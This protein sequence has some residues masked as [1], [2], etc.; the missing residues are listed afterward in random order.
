MRNMHKFKHMKALR[1]EQKEFNNKKLLT[2]IFFTNFSQIL[3]KI[4]LSFVVKI[5]PQISVIE[6]S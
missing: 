6:F 5:C 3:A 1:V 2:I 4:L